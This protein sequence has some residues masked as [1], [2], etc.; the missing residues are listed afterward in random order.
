MNKKASYCQILNYNAK[1]Q[2][3]S[4]DTGTVTD[5]NPELEICLKLMCF[6]ICRSGCI[7]LDAGCY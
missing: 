6:H 1:I 7:S 3:K 4:C 2:L 5:N